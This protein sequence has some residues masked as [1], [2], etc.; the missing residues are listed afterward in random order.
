MQPQSG[1]RPELEAAVRTPSNPCGDAL[2]SAL[3][4]LRA[5]F[6]FCP[7]LA[8]ERV[9]PSIVWYMKSVRMVKACVSPQADSLTR[10]SHQ[11]DS[12]FAVNSPELLP[13][14]NSTLQ[15]GQV[16]QLVSD[17]PACGVQVV[18]DL[19]L[20]L[21]DPHCTQ[22]SSAC[23]AP[24]LNRGRYRRRATT[25]T[26]VTGR[27]TAMVSASS[28]V[29]IYRSSRVTQ[30]LPGSGDSRTIKSCT[31]CFN[32]LEPVARTTDRLQQSPPRTRDF[33]IR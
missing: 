5:Q 31:V 19:S 10:Q 22:A 8:S 7:D 20:H 25:K 18:Q 9:L 21:S 3:C 2:R 4:T 1:A 26:V 6:C 32:Q 27:K 33:C 13:L 29:M 11:L 23:G 17:N 16:L 30:K 14:P 15:F 28:S 24:S 12:L